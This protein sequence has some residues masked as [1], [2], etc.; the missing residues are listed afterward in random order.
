MS[1]NKTT[2]YNYV[3]NAPFGGR[4]TQAQIN[5]MNAMLRS[6][7]T[8][9]DGDDRKLAYGFATAFRETGGRM[10]PVRE[11]FGNS[12][13]AVV[14][15]LDKAW[16]AGQLG[17]VSKPYWREGWFG[18]GRVQATHKHN[19]EYIAARIGLDVVNNPDLL[20]QEDVD[21]RVFWPSLIEGWWTRGRHKLSMYFNATTENPEGARRIVNGTDKASLIARYYRNFL[22]AIKAARAAQPAPEATE[23]GAEADDVAPQQDPGTLVFGGLSFT[24]IINA[25]I[26]S[27][28]ENPLQYGTG[29]LVVLA[30]AV[31]F[32]MWWTG[33][34]VISRA[35]VPVRPAM[36]ADDPEE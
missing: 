22:D 29:A 10:V 9:G 20:L 33:R 1:F 23:R 4:L 28:T 13:Q 3:R 14:R 34:L 21:A 12:T 31:A 25:V 35:P 27:I 26:S 32:Y 15:A 11:T 7:Q 8:Y 17:S 6:W 30:L 18:R 19:I 2:F 24:A 5:G 36:A 16:A